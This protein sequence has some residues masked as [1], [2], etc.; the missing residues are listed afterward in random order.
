VDLHKLTKSAMSTTGAAEAR[1]QAPKPKPEPPLEDRNRMKR[2]RVKEDEDRAKE[3]E[4]R[5]VLARISWLSILLPLGVG[6][7]AMAASLILVLGSR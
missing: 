6:L 5:D 7:A 3:P 2:N 1:I 4:L